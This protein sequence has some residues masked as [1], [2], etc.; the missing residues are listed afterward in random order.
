MELDTL[1]V[2]PNYTS[3]TL[4]TCCLV[5]S[6]YFSSFFDIQSNYVNTILTTP[7]FTPSTIKKLALSFDLQNLTIMHQLIFG[8]LRI[9]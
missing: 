4:Y 9:F 2:G 3:N 8:T 1:C 6:L 7:L 5:D